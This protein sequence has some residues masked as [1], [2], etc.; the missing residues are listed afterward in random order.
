MNCKILAMLAQSVLDIDAQ[1]INKILYLDILP[2]RA[3]IISRHITK[4]SDHYW[5]NLMAAYLEIINGHW[6]A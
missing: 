3:I 5:K 4:E 2:K 1:C 6:E